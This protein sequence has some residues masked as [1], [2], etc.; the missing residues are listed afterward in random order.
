M[1]SDADIFLW[2]G[3]WGWGQEP[4]EFQHHTAFPLSRAAAGF[5]SRRIRL[6]HS[7]LG[8]SEDGMGR[9]D[10]GC[11]KITHHLP[12]RGLTAITKLCLL[13][14]QTFFHCV[15]RRNSMQIFS[16]LSQRC[17]GC[18]G[19][20]GGGVSRPLPPCSRVYRWCPPSLCKKS[21]C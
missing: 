19:G 14:K 20:G 11:W 10:W 17:F 1:V 6:S 18:N 15:L 3:G 21:P 4:P 9:R 5:S 16:H 7:S 8:M 13:P 2:G 12:C